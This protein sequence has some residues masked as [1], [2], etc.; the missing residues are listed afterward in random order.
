MKISSSF[1]ENFRSENVR[2]KMA[3]KE[4]KKSHC[5]ISYLSSLSEKIL[6]VVE[7]LFTSRSEAKEKQ[8]LHKSNSLHEMV[9][10][11]N[12][13]KIK[14]QIIQKTPKCIGHYK[15]NPFESFRL[16]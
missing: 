9:F 2:N 14:H 6:P 15:I 3:P 4:K 12:N 16:F 7:S 5:T 11:E 10:S 13:C 1:T 8:M